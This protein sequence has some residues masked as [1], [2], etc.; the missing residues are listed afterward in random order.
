MN[1]LQSILTLYDAAP[2]WLWVSFGT[3][4]HLMSF[5][6]VCSHCLRTHKEAVSSVLWMF[7]AWSFP[8]A[9]ALLYLS[10]GVN[11]VMD[12]GFKKHI[13]DQKLLAERR[14]R[15]DEALPLAYWRA[16]HEAV[17][18]E[19]DGALDRQL[20]R[21]MNSLIPDHHML[22]G[23]RITPLVTGDETFP[24]ML[25]AIRDARHHVHLQS[26]IIADDKVGKEF[27][28]LLAEKAKSGVIIR[29]L[30]DR[31]GSTRA[32]LN[33]FFHKY[34]HLG[35][36]MKIAGWTQANPLKRQFQINLRNHRK[37]LVV[38][39]R[40]AFCGGINIHEDNVTRGGEMPIRDYHF[41]ISGPMVQELQYSFMRDWY[42]MTDED[43]D[44]LL[45]EVYFP[46]L[47]SS[48]TA[49]MRLVNSGPTAEI[50]HISDLMF[51]AIVA[52]EKQ[53]IIVTPYFVPTPDIVKAMRTTALR[54]VDVRLVVPGESNHKYAG[55]AACALYDEL[56][57]AGVRIF[58]R[59]P[60][61][62]HAKALVVD[63]TFAVVGTAN[64]DVRSLE[65]NYETSLAVSDD[66]FTEELK[67]IVLE[68][69][70]MSDELELLAWR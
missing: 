11:R 10:F 13:A 67:R 37:I 17:R 46:H 27:L 35:A 26:F 21:A 64:L 9:G 45:Q 56:L 36:N 52:A 54:G 62:M 42:F 15:E 22:G 5:L 48:G 8:V 16:V 43:P 20:N 47:A 6:L 60:P 40:R 4:M 55:L 58:E 18:G 39:G 57:E 29:V 2:S 25:E 33:G 32:F 30:F 12:K 34:Q 66:R 38:D 70:A 69:I 23:N 1:V 61:F 51:M 65:L 14:A 28:D 31:F 63:D 7:V 24:K 19:P 44:V 59:R 50:T 3:G 41:D 49:M 53:V 68:D